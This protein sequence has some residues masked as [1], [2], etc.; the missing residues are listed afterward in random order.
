MPKNVGASTHP[1]FTPLLIGNGLEE[2]PS[3]WT[4]PCMSAWKDVNILRSLG[5]HPILCR[6]ERREEAFT[7][8]K[9]E[10]HGQVNEDDVQWL[11][12]FKALLLQL[13]K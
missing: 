6:R 7:S 4:V 5:G 8:D 12:L 1:Y 2:E 13:P 11:P 10:S 3:H 9:V